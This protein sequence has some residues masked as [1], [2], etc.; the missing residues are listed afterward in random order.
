MK[1]AAFRMSVPLAGAVL[2]LGVYAYYYVVAYR[3]Y[4]LRG[5]E[6]AF[7][8]A[9][10]SAAPAGVEHEIVLETANQK[11]LSEWEREKEKLEAEKLRLLEQLRR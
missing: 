3:N 11:D 8:S 10:E 1:R 2:L 5:D 7:V 4:V 6:L 9:I